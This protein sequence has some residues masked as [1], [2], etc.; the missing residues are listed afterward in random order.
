MRPESEALEEDRVIFS[1]RRATAV[2]IDLRGVARP[3]SYINGVY[4]P[5]QEACHGWPVYKKKSSDNQWL[6]Y[7]M[8]STV[9]SAKLV[10]RQIKTNF[11]PYINNTITNEL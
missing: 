1:A 3:M 6:E 11:K 7:H 8:P 2:T 5:T 9:G 4:E 10:H